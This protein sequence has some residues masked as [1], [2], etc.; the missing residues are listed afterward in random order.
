MTLAL[1]MFLG[2]LGIGALMAFVNDDNPKIFGLGM[3]M[4]AITGK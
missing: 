2:A 1:F 4:I 3:A